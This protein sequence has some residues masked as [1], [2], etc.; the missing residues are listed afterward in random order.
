MRHIVTDIQSP[1]FDNDMFQKTCGS[2]KKYT[3][4]NHAQYDIDIIQSNEPSIKLSYYKCPYCKNWHLTE[5][6]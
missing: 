6:F 3:T 2:K 4:P 1:I 5:K